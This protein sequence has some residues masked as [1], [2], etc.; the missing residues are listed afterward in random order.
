MGNRPGWTTA[1]TLDDIAGIATHESG[2]AYRRTKHDGDAVELVDGSDK[3]VRALGERT[4]EQLLKRL[5]KE[6]GDLFRKARNSR[7][8]VYGQ[9][10]GHTLHQLV[11]ERPELPASAEGEADAL[12]L[13]GDWATAYDAYRGLEH[14]HHPR[15]IEKAGWCLMMSGRGEDVAA[16]LGPIEADLSVEGLVA[17]GYGLLGNNAISRMDQTARGR[18]ENLVRRALALEDPP[19]KVALGLALQSS[20]D[21]QYLC[22]AARLAYE[23]YPDWAFGFL[24]GARN[25]CSLDIPTTEIYRRALALIEKQPK[26]QDSPEF[27]WTCA[28]LAVSAG[29]PTKEASSHLE[30]LLIR[31]DP[32]SESAAVDQAHLVLCLTSLWG[33]AG[34]IEAC[35]RW[36]S[37]L[38]PVRGNL[39]SYL[40]MRAA[41]VDLLLALH[42]G[43]AQQVVGVIRPLVEE[44]SSRPT[45]DQGYIDE[46][47]GND[48]VMVRLND[49]SYFSLISEIQLSPRIDE[50]LG[51][52]PE[53]EKGFI[54]AWS[55][56]AQLLFH[57]GSEDAKKVWAVR[58]RLAADEARHASIDQY[59]AEA[60]S[61]APDPDWSLAGKAWT[62]FALKTPED[63]RDYLT[64]P[65]VSDE[66]TDADPVAYAEGMLE[67]LVAAGAT[68]QRYSIYQAHA[69]EALFE[70]KAFDLVREI[71]ETFLAVAP[72]FSAHFDAGYAS[73]Q[74]G[75]QEQARYHYDAALIL[76][77]NSSATAN[78]LLLLCTQPIHVP[79]LDRV[80]ATIAGLATDHEEKQKL[81]NLFRQAQ[82]RCLSKEEIRRRELAEA[83]RSYPDIVHR[84]PDFE[85][86]TFE[87]FIVLMATLRAGGHDGSSPFLAPFGRSDRLLQPRQSFS[88]AFF[89][90]LQSGAIGVDI[91]RTPAG[92][93]EADDRGRWSYRFSMVAWRLSD[94]TPAWVQHMRARITRGDVPIK[95]AGAIEVFALQLA[96][97]ELAQYLLSLAEERAWPAPS[98]TEKLDDLVA[99]MVD[100]ISVSRAYHFC[101]LGAMSASDFAAKTH[102]PPKSVATRLLNATGEKFDRHNE[103]GY[104]LRSYDRTKR[105]GRS[106]VSLSLYEDLLGWGDAGFSERIADLRFPSLND[107][108]DQIAFGAGDAADG[109][110][111]TRLH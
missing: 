60:W 92:A 35:R 107:D 18:V 91:D 69:R 37:Q 48:P 88:R 27:R 7:P 42:D 9:P 105:A 95:W 56:Q 100:Q 49:G 5:R 13:K 32:D 94:S 19:P 78:N 16:I 62:R 108:A 11:R 96:R 41:R 73:S 3:K 26:L 90:L 80:A 79:Y 81:E 54:R 71:A 87:A 31:I 21:Q 111:K 10:L 106:W 75:D 20:D 77:P 55:E 93:V 36:H 102:V 68:E 67:E 14:A 85:L 33:A 63:W 89:T 99:R 40:L 52:L 53:R 58:M 30:H 66:A 2:A 8:S 74:L 110:G 103:S 51:L 82:K 101:Y 104:P 97:D 72:S 64:E 29:Q 12:F 17:L 46:L 22:R 44:W 25:R 76:N 1:W 61:R 23:H 34:D 38:S 15:V 84:K 4:A 6:S 45:Y 65:L 24:A 109:I 43:D 28:E 47:F 59:A 57:G 70:A 98:D 83:F 39:T 50:I 86:V